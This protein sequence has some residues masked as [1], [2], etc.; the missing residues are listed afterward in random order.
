MGKAIIVGGGIG[1]LVA[2]LALR[3]LGMRICLLE[4]NG[5]LGAGGTGL[6]LWPNAL[7]QLERL[8]LQQEV[9]A[10]ARPLLKGEIFD[11]SGRPLAEVD[12]ASIRARSG[13][14]LICLREA[15]LCRVL[16]DA[17]G[18]VEVCV[19]VTCF[20][21]ENHS[22]RVVA[23]TSRGAVEGDM[24]VA[25]DG[26]RSR[27]RGQMLETDPLQYRGWM[28]WRG[29][30]QLPGGSFPEGLYREFFGRGSRLGIFAIREDLVYWSGSRNG[31]AGACG[32]VGPA[33]RAEALRAFAGWPDPVPSVI[34]TTPAED[35][36]RSGVYDTQ[37]LARWSD[38]RAVLLGD[39][40]HPMTPDLGQGACQAIEDALCL[41]ECVVAAATV[42]QALRA[43]ERQGQERTASLVAR[44]RRMGRMRQWQHPVM[45]R[46]RNG[47]M[48]SIPPSVLLKLFNTR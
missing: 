24:L 4:R 11:Q 5:R 47:L 39:A 35:L 38:G 3:R 22:G 2:A 27:L 16:L 14:P 17:L 9:F 33:H 25:A 32:P 31:P 45:A 20:A 26:M 41:A 1:G 34:D 15:D 36:V 12:L 10:H 43:Y 23:Q 21:Y 19:G 6:T 18:E 40:A 44:S 28:T 29:V 13:K 42:P 37:P 7:R 30:A 8:G 48:R 46:F